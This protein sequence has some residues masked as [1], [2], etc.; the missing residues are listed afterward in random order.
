M[1][2]LHGEL[3]PEDRPRVHAAYDAIQRVALVWRARSME[4][5]AGLAVPELPAPDDDPQDYADGQFEVLVTEILRR[6][7]TD[8]D[9]PTLEGL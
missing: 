2:A 3:T 1:S 4:A 6:F 8:E 5:A 9:P 7:L